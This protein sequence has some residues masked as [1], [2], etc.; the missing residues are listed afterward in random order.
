METSTDRKHPGPSLG[1]ELREGSSQRSHETLQGHPGPQLNKPMYIPQVFRTDP[2]AGTAVLLC[3]ATILWCIRVIRRRQRGAD[4][5]LL[6][7]LGL[8]AVSQALRILKDFGIFVPSHPFQR[9]DDLVNL[10]TAGLYMIGALLLEI[11]SKDRISSEVHLRLVTAHSGNVPGLSPQEAQSAVLVLTRDGRIAGCNQ[12][13]E[14]ILGR[15][16]HQLIGTVPI[17]AGTDTLGQEASEGEDR[18][19]TV[20][21]LGIG[22]SNTSA[23]IG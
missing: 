12:A 22:S 13:A 5:F 3:L 21:R 11:S 8:I 19:E 6:G 15:D 10:I 1:R 20:E 7:L 16:R 2:L 18:A 14:M 4:R 9:L 23:T 17:F